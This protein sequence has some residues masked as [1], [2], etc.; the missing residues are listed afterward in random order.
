MQSD[1]G[2]RLYRAIGRHTRIRRVEAASQSAY[3]SHLNNV[4]ND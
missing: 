1:D 3:T 4:L 2:D